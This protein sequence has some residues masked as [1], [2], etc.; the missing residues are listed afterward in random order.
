M[1]R[2]TQ[3]SRERFFAEQAIRALG[4]DWI[5]LPDER[6]NPDFVVAD[7]EHRFGLEVVSVF[8]GDKGSIGSSMKK[9]E[10]ATALDQRVA[11]S[12]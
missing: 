8:T 6:E 9:S 7:G 5:I 10:P 11:G 2:Q 4:K 3:K 1:T 12:V